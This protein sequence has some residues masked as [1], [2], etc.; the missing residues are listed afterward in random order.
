[1]EVECGSG[2]YI[3]SLGR[4]LARALGTGAVMA[5]LERTAIGRFHVADACRAE[6]L[7][8][9]GLDARLLPAVLAVEDL[10][11][12]ELAADELRL[13]DHGRPLRNRWSVAAPEVAA[14]DQAG[15][16]AAIL[17]PGEEGCLRP[18]RNFHAASR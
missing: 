10:P 9:E 3:R 17:E 6:E 13:L 14:M 1:M 16:L 11:R 15:Q 2:T 12:V 7:S 4:D 5:E 18:V 8:R